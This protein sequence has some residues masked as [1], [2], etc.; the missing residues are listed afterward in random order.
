MTHAL[1]ERARAE[2]TP[3]ID[4][5]TVTFVWE[6]ETPPG[7][8]ADFCDWDP[9]NPVHLSEAAP[10]VWMH[11]VTLPRNAYIEYA[12]VTPG[13]RV[14]D[15][16]NP[17]QITN[18]MGK[19]NHT[20]DMPDARHTPLVRHGKGVPRGRVTRHILRGDLPI[21]GD[22]RPVLLYQPA[23]ETPCPLLYVLDGQDYYKRARLTVIVDNLIARQRIRPIAL[24]MP[25]HGGPARMV[26]YLCSEATIGF[27]V[28][29]VLDLA[30]SHLNLIDIHEQPGSYGILGASMGGLMALYAGLRLPKVFGTVISQSGAFGFE[31]MGQS[32]LIHDLLRLYDLAPVTIWM[33]VGRY[34]WLLEANRRMRGAL[35]AQGYDP[36]YREYSGGHN[37]TSWRDE[38]VLALEA[39]YG[40]K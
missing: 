29:E 11:R 16:F 4:D 10:G 35:R 9:E 12:Y 19:M 32:A 24:A 1:L 13:G 30:R 23:V 18:G 6:G 25:Y 15:P 5:T 31:L 37:Y 21:V 28:D 7:L 2:G 26:E 34:E 27:L 8:L 38:V 40:M 33:D 20:F 39:V 36:V 3:L 14:P 17:R 22:Q